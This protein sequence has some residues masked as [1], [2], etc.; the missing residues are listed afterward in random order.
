MQRIILHRSRAAKTVG[1]A[2]ARLGYVLDFELPFPESLHLTPC[3]LSQASSQRSRTQNPLRSPRKCQLLRIQ[4]A[5]CIDSHR[6]VTVLDDSSLTI[7]HRP[8]ASKTITDASSSSTPNAP[9]ES[10]SRIG[11]ASK[12]TGKG[13]VWLNEEGPAART[14]I[15]ELKRARAASGG[16]LTRSPLALKR[17]GRKAA[18]EVG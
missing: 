15:V 16:K 3:T 8:P 4:E 6:V 17:R 12:Q 9:N 7:L 2:I 14:G 18:V 10:F 13:R 5:R 1:S 11:R